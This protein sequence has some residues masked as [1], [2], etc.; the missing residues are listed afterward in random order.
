MITLS[1]SQAQTVYVNA[2]TISQGDTIR[3][4]SNSYSQVIFT[5]AM[6]NIEWQCTP[7]ISIYNTSITVTATNNGTI[8]MLQNGNIVKIFKFFLLSNPIA[9]GFTDTIHACGDIFAY[10]LNALNSNKG[11]YYFWSTG[12][13]TQNLSANTGGNYWV[14]IDNG[15]GIAYD[16]TTILVDH[17]N[18]VNL[19][20]DR[21]LC[22]HDSINITTNNSNVTHYVWSTGASSSSIWISTSGNYWATTTDATGCISTDTMYLTVRSP[23]DQQE[24]CMVSFD[25]LS[26]KNKL[27]WSQHLEE[28]IESIEIQKEISLNTWGIIGTISNMETSFIDASSMPQ[29]NSDSYRLLIIDSCGN[30]STASEAHTTITLV[31]SYTPGTNVLGFTWSHYYINGNIVAPNYTIYGIDNNGDTQTIGSVPGSQNY[32]NYNNPSTTYVKFFVGFSRNCESKTNYLIKS[33]YIQN[34]VYIDENTLNDSIKI[35]PT[36]S[37]SNGP[38]T[39]ESTLD[40]ENVSMYTPLGEIIHTTKEKTFTIKN[41]GIY[42]VYITTKKGTVVKKIIIK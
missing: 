7:G 25:T 38:I 21:V 5:T 17:A 20:S 31:T 14:T 8:G 29:T 15:C 19:G 26:Y 1:K 40:I 16:T 6:S 30:H 11:C 36:I 42:F 32:Y 27:T 18:D 35:Y 37:I 2:D 24:L 9:P 13:T 23:Y 4:C 22:L 34:N 10:T 3:F 39:I 33:N 28:G 12:A 41:S